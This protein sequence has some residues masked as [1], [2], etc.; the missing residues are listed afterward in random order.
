ME[1][2]G[3]DISNVK[4]KFSYPL[5]NFKRIKYKILD[6]GMDFASH[7]GGTTEE[8]R[9]YEVIT[10]YRKCKACMICVEACPFHA[11]KSKEISLLL[12]IAEMTICV[13]RVASKA[14]RGKL[15]K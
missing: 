8:K 12:A 10:N 1:I 15:Y 5:S 4:R 13:L 7:L 9:A 14:I 11:I 3:E 6:F 2:V